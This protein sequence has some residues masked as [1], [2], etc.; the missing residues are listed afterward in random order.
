MSFSQDQYQKDVIKELRGIRKSMETISKVALTQLKAD[1]RAKLFAKANDALVS[2]VEEHKND[3]IIAVDF[4]GTLCKNAWPGIGEPIQPVIDYILKEQTNGARII[5]WTNR[6]GEPL[7]EA[8]KW[9]EQQGIIF[10]AVNANLPEIIE[11]FGEDTR[12]IFANEYL[13]DRAVLPSQI[14]EESV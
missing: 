10:S 11:A 6:A 7:D 2:H 14:M 13:D 5:L 4:D 12:K 3:K 9:C 1:E 8:V